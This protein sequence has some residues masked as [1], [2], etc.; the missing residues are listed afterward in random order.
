M[1]RPVGQFLA[2]GGIRFLRFAGVYV[3][4]LTL[5]SFVGRI[6]SDFDEPVEKVDLQEILRGIGIFVLALLMTIGNEM[7][8]K[9]ITISR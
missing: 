9:K 4:S 8:I 2:A 6:I 1:T 7:V 5:I 3:L